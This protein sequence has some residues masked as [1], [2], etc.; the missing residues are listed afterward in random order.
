MYLHGPDYIPVGIICGGICALAAYGKGRN[1]VG[2]FLLGYIFSIFALIGILLCSNQKEARSHRAFMEQENRRLR[3]QLRQEQIK[4][5]TFRSHTQRRLDAHDQKLAIDTRID[6]QLLPGA[7]ATAGLLGQAGQ[8]QQ[9]P[10]AQQVAAAPAAGWYYAIDGQTLGPVPASQMVQMIRNRVVS[11]GTLVW[12]EGMAD[13]MPAS[14][15]PEFSSLV[16]A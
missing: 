12:I 11:G 1:V 8:G 13:W 5:E 6:D 7:G 10:F 15:V 4:S 2:W 9:P 3:E 14:R 16:M